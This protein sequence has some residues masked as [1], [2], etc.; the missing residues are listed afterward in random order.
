[1]YN[2]NSLFAISYFQKIIFEP[3]FRLVSRIK[4]NSRKV[5]KFFQLIREF[6]KHLCMKKNPKKWSKRDVQKSTITTFEI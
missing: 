5:S 6:N 1:M 4:K 3:H 2:K